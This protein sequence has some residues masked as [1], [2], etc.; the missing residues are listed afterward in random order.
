[1]ILTT[2]WLLFPNDTEL[3]KRIRYINGQRTRQEVENV[4]VL[5]SYVQYIMRDNHIST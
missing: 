3:D 5:Y 4:N 1:M 2:K